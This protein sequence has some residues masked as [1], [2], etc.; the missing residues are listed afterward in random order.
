MESADAPATTS[1][2]DEP[3]S[4]Q[5]RDS[6]AAVLAAVRVT[7]P[8]IALLMTLAAAWLRW[9]LATAEQVDT[10]SID[11]VRVASEVT[12]SLLSYNPAMGEIDVRAV[13]MHLTGAFRD[14]YSSLV[15]DVVI[16]AARQK[17]IFSTATVPAAAL[18][19]ASQNHAIVVVFADQMTIVGHD[20]PTQSA[21][22]IRVT[23]DKVDGRWLI[24]DFTPIR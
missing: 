11:T 21:S 9:N 5:T 20:A 15:D 17:Q 8:V 16:P 24:S 3:R 1:P 10:A 22:S 13:E 4:A 19:S 12:V 2:S 14:A 6:V 18:I 7:L 23:L